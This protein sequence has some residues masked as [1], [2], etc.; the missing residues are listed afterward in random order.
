MVESMKPG[1]II[2]DLAAERGGNCE[3]PQPGKTTDH[4]GVRI[5]GHLNL[6][7]E[8]SVNASSLYS[9]NLLAFVQTLVDSEQGELAID[10]E[11][12]IVQG[13]L[14]T[15]DGKIVNPAITKE[16]T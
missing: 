1:S 7:G 3:L 9:R 4:N 6:A 11:D 5:L 14:V 2:V 12:E 15:R 8:L 10:W 16:G 13:T